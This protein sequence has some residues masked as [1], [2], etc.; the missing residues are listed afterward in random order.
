[1]NKIVLIVAY[2][3]QKQIICVNSSNINLVKS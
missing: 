1:M 3:F 2:I